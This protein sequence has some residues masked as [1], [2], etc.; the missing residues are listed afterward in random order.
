MLPLR[1]RLAL[2][3][4]AV[5]VPLAGVLAAPPEDAPRC[6]A[7]RV[8]DGDTLLV[9]LDDM[10]R[11]ETTPRQPR[12]TADRTRAGQKALDD[13]PLFKL[14]WSEYPSW[15]V[16][17]V[18]SELGL[19]DGAKGKQG[20]LEKKW[21]VDIELHLLEYEPCVQLY[22]TGRCDAVCVTN[23]DVLASSLT[24]QSVAILPTSTSVGA[25]A[26]I[27]AGID[28]SDRKAAV[29]EL[30]RHKVY[31]PAKSI[32]EYAFV[33]NLELLGED[34]KNYNFT[35]EPAS[36]AAT[37]MLA[38]KASHNAI[39]VWN[40]S[41][42][43]VL[44]DR[45]DARVLFDSST[46]PEEIIDMVVMGQDSLKKEKGREFA[47][48]VIDTYYTMNKLLQSPN[49]ETANKVLVKIGEKF[50]NLGLEDMKKVVE[51]TRF[52][53]T[54]EEALKLFEGKELPDTMK[55]NVLR[56]ALG[57]KMIDKEPTLG[58]GDGD[59]AKDAQFRFDPS[60]IKQV[61]K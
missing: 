48:C 43:Q 45:K 60:Y 10:V 35:D 8:L 27:V 33:R 9:A 41:V 18:A 24:R 32:S 40:P 6:K 61:K 21:G 44:K 34:P 57:L 16:F 36:I 46:I 1:F 3:A 37:A 17:G 52:Y 56:L 38:K 30:R 7:A 13:P 20:A 4:A 39:M 54:P 59:K 12:P 55:K 28:T 58:Y 19:I 11:E 14:A 15:S 26:C 53:K 47:C 23:I 25:D 51:Q 2:L 42:L 49:K 5:L 29:K 22:A 31:G 50:S